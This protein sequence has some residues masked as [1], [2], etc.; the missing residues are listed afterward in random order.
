ML[1]R[2]CGNKSHSLLMRMQDSTA[3]LKD[4]LAISHKLNN[5]PSYDA[6][7]PLLG[8]HSKVM[9]TYVHT[10]TCLWTLISASFIY[11][12]QILKTSKMPLSR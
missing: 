9:K 12:C 3:P 11:Y 1:V 2:M 5:L 10:K 8:T 4:S 6:A 7:I